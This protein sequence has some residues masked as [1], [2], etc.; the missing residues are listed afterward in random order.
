MRVDV[1]K[2]E[3]VTSI[4]W[5]SDR[6]IGQCTFLRGEVTSPFGQGTLVMSVNYRA[7]DLELVVY[8]EKAVPVFEFLTTDP[9]AYRG[10]EVFFELIATAGSDGVEWMSRAIGEQMDKVF[11]EGRDELAAE[12]RGLLGCK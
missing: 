6:T 11:Q 2:P 3:R 10:L 8:G 1:N 12:L 9:L 7:I 4:A 5:K